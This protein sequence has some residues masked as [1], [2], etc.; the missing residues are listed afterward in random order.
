[1]TRTQYKRKLRTQRLL[2]LVFLAISVFVIVMAAAG[3]SFIEKDCTA[4]FITAPLGFWL[5]LS[6]KVVID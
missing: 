2:G 6:R 1:M 5:C 4:V 3:T